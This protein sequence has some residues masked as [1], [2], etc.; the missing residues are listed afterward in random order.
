[1][2]LDEKNKSIYKNMERKETNH[3][4]LQ[5]LRLDQSAYDHGIHHRQVLS[6]Q[7]IGPRSVLVSPHADVILC[8]LPRDSLRSL[9]VVAWVSIHASSYVL[10]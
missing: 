1:M 6:G 4:H 3:L 7:G 8:P 5:F 10:T 2:G 9:S